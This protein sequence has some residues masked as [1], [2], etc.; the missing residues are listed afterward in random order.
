MGWWPFRNEKMVP[1]APVELTEDERQECET[2]I[3]SVTKA[4]GGHYA[5]RKDVA[6]S[7]QRS[8]IAVCLLGRAERFLVSA[9]SHP[10]S[11]EGACRAGA[12]ACATY[13][14]SI[15]FYDF[16]CILERLQKQEEAR[17]IFKEFLRRRD[18]EVSPDPVQQIML[19]ERDV[20]S[21]VRYARQQ[22]GTT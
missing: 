5:V 22:I 20:A 9:D 19:N 3:R 7:F 2:Y 16:A 1:L 18:L 8:L 6:D 12:K 11:V 21:A 13:P 15:N 10:E 4:E 17:E 14:L